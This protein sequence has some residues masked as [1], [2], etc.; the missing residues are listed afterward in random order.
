MVLYPHRWLFTF[1]VVVVVV[2]ASFGF[3]CKVRENF[4]FPVFKLSPRDEHMCV[5][6]TVIYVTIC[7]HFVHGHM[8]CK[9]VSVRLCVYVHDCVLTVSV[10]WRACTRVSVHGSACSSVFVNSRL[11]R[12]TTL[13]LTADSLRLEGTESWLEP[14]TLPPLSLHGDRERGAQATPLRCRRRRDSATSLCGGTAVTQRGRGNYR[15]V[16]HR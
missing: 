15:L 5:C 2:T 8:L 10:R 16:A 4:F 12:S 1:L 7:I 6:T 3:W 9:A 14:L 13:A 11:A